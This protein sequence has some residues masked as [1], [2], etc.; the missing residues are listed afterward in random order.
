M[1]KLSESGLNTSLYRKT[2]GREDI[3][4]LFSFWRYP[5]FWVVLG[6]VLGFLLG[7]HFLPSFFPLF[8]FFAVLIV[9]QV[10]FFHSRVFFLLFLTGWVVFGALLFVAGFALPWEF[11]REREGE[12]VTLEG[13]LVEQDGKMYLSRIG[14]FWSYSPTLFLRG[15]DA[16]SRPF[17]YRRVRVSGTFKSFASCANPGGR[18]LRVHY[19]RKRI[20]GYLEVKE[21]VPLSSRNPWFLFLRW[22]WEKRRVFLERFAGELGETYAPLFSAVFLG[23]K[24]GDFPEKARVFQEMGVYHLFCVSGF[25][26]A[27]LGGILWLALRRLL[28]QRV[29]LWVTFPFTFF[30]LAFCGFVPSAS[31][32]W[33]M[34]SL[35]FLSRKMGRVVTTMGILLSAF[36]LMFLLQPEIVFAP[37]AQLSFASTA[38]VLLFFRFLERL[39]KRGSSGWLVILRYF[40]SALFVTG[41]VLLVSFPFLVGNRLTLSSLVFLGN[42]L[43]P[44]LVEGVLFLALLSPLLGIFAFGRLVLVFCLQKL[45]AV[46]LRLSELLGKFVP[47]V[48]FDFSVGRNILWGIVVWSVVVFVLLG[49][50]TRRR[51][52]PILAVLSL[53]GG[54]LLGSFWFPEEGFVVFDVGQGLACG[55]FEGNSGILIDTGGIIRGYG[56]VASSI[57][58]PS[59]RF[60]GISSLLGIFL[61]HGHRDHAGGI[62]RLC[63]VFPETPLFLPE[64]LSSF[65]RL[66]VFNDVFLEILPV[67]DVQGPATVYRLHTPWGRIL[68]LGDVED[69][70]SHLAP[71]DFQFLEADVVVLPH[72]GSYSES[73][74]RLLSLSR[75]RWAIISVG[76]NPYGHPDSRTVRV[77]EELG[78]PYFITRRD[79]AVEYYPF[80]GRGRIK[81]IGKKKL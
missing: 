23:L 31:R 35:F 50:F 17:V 9:L 1:W 40:G 57:L 21:M 34:M 12:H 74:H 71:H 7:E 20:F 11:F 26:M 55:F 6:A 54:V 28:P 67:R 19:F 36:F 2:W 49:F 38:G 42:L 47:H 27:L 14:G 29:M 15:N 64:H 76:E 22:V 18:D 48:V 33:I 32:A 78:V 62:E 51:I 81:R 73:L 63:A 58:L 77:L 69:I 79:G 80:M 8:L 66:R 25:H 45:L 60:R 46:L 39:L 43:L 59:L 61:T 41:G 75:C 30:Y 16:L 44:P 68:I 72:H 5:L 3:P 52:F 53:L 24:E 4:P 65:E 70:F 56:S 37:G 10:L 13:Y